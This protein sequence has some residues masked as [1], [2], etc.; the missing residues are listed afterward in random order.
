[1]SLTERAGDAR[2]DD[3]GDATVEGFV[4]AWVT[5]LAGT[6][7]VPMSAVEVERFLHRQTYFLTE[8]VLCGSP[9]RSERLAYGVGVSLVGAH[10]V[11]PRALGCTLGVLCR[12]LADI[13]GSGASLERQADLLERVRDAQ[14]SLA[15]GY[16]QALR[17]R[18]LDEQE[19]IR[20]AAMDA[21]RQAEDALRASEA[22]FRAVFTESGVGIGLAD[23]DGH[24]VEVNQAFATMLGYS[25]EE[26]LQLQVMDLVHPDDTATMW[27][28][29]EEMICGELDYVRLEKR[30]RHREGGVV[31]TNL[32]A[33]L[34]RDADGKPLYTLA[35]VEDI[36]ERR[37]L[38]DR[39][40]HQALHD[41]L[42]QLPNRALFFE[43]LGGALGGD[44]RAGDGGQRRVGVCYLDLDGFKV[45]NDTLGHDVGDELLIAV[46]RRLGRCVSRQ[47][48]LVARMGGDEFVILVQD[49]TGTDE[50][51]ALAASVLRAF[52]A[53]FDVAGHQLL[54]SASIGVVERPI[55]GT[56]AAEV[57]KAADATLYWA[58][59][60]GRGRLAVFDPAR[61][62][63]EKTRYALSGS[64]RSGLHRGEFT[65]EYQPLVALVDGVVRGVEALVR[66]EHPRLGR[67]GPDEFIGLAEET[68]VIVPLGRWVLEQACRQAREW[69]LLFGDGPFVSVNLAARQACDPTVVDDV[70]RTLT[71]TG[72]PADRLQLELTESAVM[73]TSGQPLEA[74]RA[75][76]DLGVVLAIDDFGTGYSNLAYL[77]RLPVHTLKL[78]GSFIE[79]LRTPSQS[80][81]GP[82]VATLVGLAHTLGLTVTAEGVETAAQAEQLHGLGCD[83]AQGWYF[84]RPMSPARITEMLRAGAA[85]GPTL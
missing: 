41:S 11:G 12:H 72:L 14:E 22:R 60:D 77:R 23:M 50:V 15:A 75:L 28:A 35:M 64:M 78:A 8:A 52:D 18:T 9:R 45:I 74:L 82:I 24:I 47:G 3:T 6:S 37:L 54:V 71:E 61:N 76:G 34:I 13:V 19:S 30:Y 20:R 56:C 81:D 21:R 68:G 57:M 38:E 83:L 65:I 31:W 85:L 70:A 1:M 66:W 33:S 73:G 29:Y 27:R 4:D 69:Q 25:V 32:T 49:S 63:K 62:A 39:L 5:A 26:F 44:A 59:S 40:R 17:D 80:V 46:A 7:H 2:S 53:P 79:G 51:A 16:V 36:S 42:T 84:A 55:V 58:K 43:R 48:R 67:L 10:F